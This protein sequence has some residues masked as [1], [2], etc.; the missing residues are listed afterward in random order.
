MR[1]YVNAVL[2][3][4]TTPSTQAADFYTSCSANNFELAVC[5]KLQ[6]VIS[7]SYKGNLAR[8]AGALCTRLGACSTSAAYTVSVASNASAAII[9]TGAPDACTVEGVAGGAQVAMVEATFGA[10][11]TTCCLVN[12]LTAAAALPATHTLQLEHHV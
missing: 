6:A 1:P 12:G 11:G 4:T 3:G 5:S 10:T 9:L 8:R 7:S 2:N